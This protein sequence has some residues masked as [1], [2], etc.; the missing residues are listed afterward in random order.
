MMVMIIMI[1]II[2]FNIFFIFAES[3]C[4]VDKFSLLAARYENKMAICEL[5]EYF[6][7]ATS[8]E[9]LARACATNGEHSGFTLPQKSLHL[10]L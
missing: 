4:S 3:T 5:V 1:M 10:V 8:E 7:G 6:D 2:N 9:C